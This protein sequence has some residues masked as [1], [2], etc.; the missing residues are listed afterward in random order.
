MP[1]YRE[2]YERVRRWYDRF[3]TTDQGRPHDASPENYVDD[4]YSFFLNCYHLKDW[5]KRD[6]TVP[7]GTQQAVEDWI[8][9]NRPLKLCADICNGH[10]HL[11]LKQPRSGESPAFG[12]L[13]YGLSL[14]SGLP[15]ISLKYEVDTTAGPLDAFEIAT[16]CM[17]AW[18]SF[19][20]MLSL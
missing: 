17:R 14:G 12:T 8:N 4:I 9:G 15:V 7:T 11:V 16:D 2:Q 18:E 3:A 6:P 19:L 10:K 1:K 20:S 5:I 13:H